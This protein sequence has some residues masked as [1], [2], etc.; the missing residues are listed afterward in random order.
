[1]P[2]ILARELHYGGFTTLSIDRMKVVIEGTFEDCMLLN[3]HLRTATRILYPIKRMRIHNADQL[4]HKVKGFAWEKVLKKDSYVNIDGFVK[5]SSIRDSRFAMLRVKDGVVDRL[6]KRW[7]R[8]PNTG[9]RKSEACIYLHWVE[10]QAI[11][12]IDT[13]G[14]TISKH[15]YRI[16]PHKAPMAESLAASCILASQWQLDMPFINPMC[17]SG[18]LAIEAAM[19]ASNTSPGLLR[20]TFGFMYWQ[21]Y[22][23]KA[24]KDMVE[25][26]KGSVERP[27]S[28]YHS[29]R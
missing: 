18:T 7:G 24:W 14:E 28:G 4:Y 12:Y 22:D 5:H 26:A 1:M 9:P 27:R 25:A 17:G 2:R 6:R 13:S 10:E 11:L 8:R 21:M 3:L 16:Q 29:Y 19:I 15:N 23:V 20:K